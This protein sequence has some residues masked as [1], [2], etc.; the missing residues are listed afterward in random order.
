[1]AFWGN[2]NDQH[3]K[4][5]LTPRRHNGTV[6]PCDVWSFRNACGTRR[7]HIYLYITRPALLTRSCDGY[8]VGWRNAYESGGEGEIGRGNRAIPDCPMPC[9]AAVIPNVLDR[10]S[11]W[12]PQ[13]IPTIGNLLKHNQFCCTNQSSYFDTIM[14]YHFW[15]R[16]EP[17]QQISYHSKC[18]PQLCICLQNWRWSADFL[19]LVFHSLGIWFCREC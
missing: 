14:G 2:G 17:F 5:V 8:C 16:V 3:F 4:K 10:S 12:K 15:R 6:T 9:C 7:S 1:M 18:Q 13:D 19:E 11:C